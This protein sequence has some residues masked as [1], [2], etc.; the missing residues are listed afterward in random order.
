MERLKKPTAPDTTAVSVAETPEPETEPETE[1]RLLDSLP[2]T[3]DLGGTDIRVIGYVEYETNPNEISVE[4]LTGEVINDAVYNRNLNV[5]KRLNVQIVPNVSPIW[6]AA[7]DIRSVI[8]SGSDDLDVCFANAY[9]SFGM[10][11]DGLF[12]DLFSVDNLDF[13]KP[14]WSQGFVEPAAINNRLYLATGPMSL[15]FYRY[16][17]IEIFNKSLFQRTGFESPYQAVLEGRWTLEYQNSLASAFYID[18]NGNGDRDAEDQYGFVTRMANDTSI[19]DGYWSS[20]NLHTIAKDENGYY[21]VDI[22]LERFSSAIDKLLS[23]MLGDGTAGM[24]TFDDDIYKRFSEG[25][26]AMSNAR[27]HIVESGDFR[28]M[29]D[30]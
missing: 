29:E 7:G 2:E 11:A 14:Y 15:G 30:D 22:D 1:G 26:A 6:N 23:L 16:L 21:T 25:R 18:L 27:L 28:D 8:Q 9:L 12:L 4:E 5:E 3:V 13:A 19:N 20:L 17:M 10:A 24:C